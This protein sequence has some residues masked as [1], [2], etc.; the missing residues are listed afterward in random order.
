MADDGAGGGGGVGLSDS[1][2]GIPGDLWLEVT[3]ASMSTLQ[4]IHVLQGN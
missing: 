2:W 1:G 3:G 4:S